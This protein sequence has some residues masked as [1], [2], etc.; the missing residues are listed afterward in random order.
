MRLVFLGAPGAG[1]GTQA[2]QV[3]KA[4][5]L[6]HISTGDLLRE[7]LKKDSELST[8]IKAYVNR[9]ELVPDELMIQMVQ[10]RLQQED[11]KKGFLLDGFPRTVAQ[12]DALDRIVEIDSVIN[13]D[14]DKTKLADR[15]GKRRVC[16]NCGSVFSADEV[17]NGKCL[18]CTGE[19]VQ[20]ADDNYETVMNRLKVFE[21]QTEPLIEYY[22][23]KNILFNID[24]DRS[25]EQV[26]EAIFAV[27]DDKKRAS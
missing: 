16:K 15:I 21:A 25:V 20:R 4:Y 27:L 9:G 7:E 18:V 5:N 12:A 22:Q 10:E 19:M 24:G 26:S 8:K 1:K 11:A 13:I 23:K 17:E 2:A 6:A 3:C 14:V